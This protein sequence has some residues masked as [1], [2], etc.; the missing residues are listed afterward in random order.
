[1][2]C[3]FCCIFFQE[4][5]VDM[6]L[7]LLESI[8]IYGNLNNTDILIY[9]S[10]MFM[11]I[12]K[13]NELFDS[14]IIKFE[15]ND[16]YDNIDKSC[17]SRLDF[18]CLNSIKNYDK[19]LYLDTDILI[20]DDINKLFNICKE[21][22]LYVLE[23]GTI[24]DKRDFWGN[25]LF[26][27]EVN[28]YEDKSA[29]TTGILLFNN[30]E[31]IKNLFNDIKQYII[32]REH[33]FSCYDQPYIVYNAFKYNL[34]NNKSLKK[35]AINDDI[36][37]DDDMVI[38]HF[39]GQA[40]QYI[41]KIFYMRNY[42]N[43]LNKK[44]KNRMMIFDEKKPPVKNTKLPLVGLCISYNYFDTLK[45][46]LPVNYLHFEKIFIVTQQNDFETIE[47]CKN[48]DNVIVLFYNFKYDDKTFD[49]YGALNYGQRIIY[50]LYPDNWYLIID[51]DIILPNNLIDILSQEDLNEECIYGAVR[52]NVDLS[53]EL[54][55]KKQILISEKNIN[56]PFNNIL[57][58]IL[59]KSPPSILGCFQLYKKHVYHCNIC[60]NA[61]GGD[62]YFG[63]DN[64]KLFCNL[65]NIYYFHLGK[66]AINWN[67]KVENFIDD[68]N[69]SLTD[70]YFKCS[71]KYNNNIYY[72]EK[73]EIV[74][75]GNSENI[76]NDI[77]TCSDKFRYDVYNFFKENSNF[78]IAEIGAHKGY[79][80]KILAK[81][82]SK[83]Y[84]VDNNKE[85]TQFN[86]DYNKNYD[87]I[88]YINLDIYKDS[89]NIIPKNI[90]VVF[91][92]AMHTYEHCK[93]D[94]INSILT[95]KDL[96]YIIFDDYGVWDGVRVIVDELLQNGILKFERFI[97]LNDVPGPDGIVYNVNEGIICSV[98]NFK[99]KLDN[100]SFSWDIYSITFLDN[101]KMNA[102]GDGYYTVNDDN[103]IIAYFGGKE[104]N[105]TFNNNLTE[106]ISIRKDDLVVVKGKLIFDFKN[107]LVN[108]KFSWGNSYITFLDNFKMDA[109]GDGNYTNIDS[110]N[111]IANFLGK[112]HYI[113]F[114]DNFTEFI[115]IQKND[116]EI[117]IGKII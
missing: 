102:F 84:A 96:K 88:K 34:Y 92:D 81:I 62:Y 38:H 9:T 64:F 91:I 14:K 98:N 17:K 51:S 101:F 52:S 63:Y 116:L 28:N 79:T 82:F 18:F 54:L 70:I 108:K 117:I 100:K 97:G 61:G 109:F 48:F 50:N 22:I 26:G 86:K 15:I 67:G 46:M 56:F 111:I 21:D 66:T 32:N 24:D 75:F 40:G 33:D 72:N 104:H 37:I 19:I 43:N 3:I 2:N 25:T 85:W 53:S 42:L 12:I 59:G 106:Y 16:K 20:K 103:N 23:E 29:F 71:K 41:H 105:I 7:L 80:T 39:P 57:H 95:F 5:Y 74:K 76:D 47:F 113:K 4:K 94:I 87:N 77:W 60:N 27:N 65:E 99:N 31:N 69:I 93:S 44:Y 36:N 107:I 58:N 30:C 114:N 110:Y 13:N 89:W 68:I 49:K 8:L 112:K 78:T 11:N 10:T 83:V 45:F 35:Y 55:N 90:D 6:F 115:S 73:C 1:M